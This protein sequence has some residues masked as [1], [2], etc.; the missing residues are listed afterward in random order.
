MT[1]G[2]SRHA[3]SERPLRFFFRGAVPLSV[4]RGVAVP[5]P[6]LLVPRKKPPRIFARFRRG[7][8][9]SIALFLALILAAP[10]AVY[11]E[12]VGPVALGIDAA[13]LEAAYREEESLYEAGPE[14]PEIKEA[15]IKNAEAVPLK[16]SGHMPKAVYTG[17]MQNTARIRA[18]MHSDSQTVGYCQKDS[19]V[20][21][22]SYEPAWLQ[23]VQ[24]TSEAWIT[25]YVPRHMVDRISSVKEGVLPYGA[26]P[27]AYTAVVKSDTMLL[28][29]PTEDAEPI[30][31]L[32]EGTRIAVLS[33][34][35]GWAKLLRWRQY[36]YV[37]LD[38]IE[39]LTPVYDVDSAAPG[40]VISAFNT[41]FSTDTSQLNQDR[42]VNIAQACY[43]IS[44]VM[45]PGDKFAF[46]SVGGPYQ[47]V[48][49]YRKAMSYLNGEAVLSTGGGV[50]QVSSTLYNV[51]LCLPEGM[52]VIRRRAHGANGAVYLPHGVDAA[53]GN[54]Q[55]DLVFRNVFPFPIRIDAGEHDGVL[56]ISMIKERA[57]E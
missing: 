3:G 57:A 43:Y 53:V 22:L 24:G 18:E 34:E 6:R 35:N 32:T 15:E 45:H 52:E 19:T 48:R 40:D 39:A 41:F 12:F 16:G 1:R 33:I 54:E 23:V 44:I 37:Y 17:T 26:L 51:L 47:A 25:G 21:I 8:T 7:A 42:I 20:Q 10:R 13:E 50:C 14:E 27:A 9:L 30:Y 28:E 56:F 29:A 38:A 5:S 55:L 46:N 4:R 2:V 31:L 36:G 49:G 11:A